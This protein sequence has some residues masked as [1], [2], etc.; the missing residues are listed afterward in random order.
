[1]GEQCSDHLTEQDYKAR[2]LVEELKY[3]LMEGSPLTTFKVNLANAYQPQEGEKD[4]GLLNNVLGLMVRNNM[5][6]NQDIL[7]AVGAA[8]NL[9]QSE[10]RG[11]IQE[12]QGEVAVNR[13]GQ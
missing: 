9:K 11:M 8:M 10:L 4:Q 2:A 5:I 13:S 3:L 1:M 6:E 7:G 12:I